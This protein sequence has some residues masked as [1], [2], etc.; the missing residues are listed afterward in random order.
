MTHNIVAYTQYSA[1]NDVCL[2]NLGPVAF[3]SEAR[4]SASSNK[5]HEK[6]ENLHT[7]SLMHKILSSSANSTDLL[8]VFDSNITRR[9]QE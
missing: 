6:V 2:A 3:F 4:L 5:H 8:F 9:R 1:N 7:V